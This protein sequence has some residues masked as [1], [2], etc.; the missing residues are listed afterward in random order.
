[1]CVVAKIDKH[2]NKHVEDHY[3]AKMY[4]IVSA[5]KTMSGIPDNML[6]VVA[7]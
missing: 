5:M 4:N 2:R 3:V 7:V 1:M 6:A